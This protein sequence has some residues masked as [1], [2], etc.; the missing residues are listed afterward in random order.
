MTP[1]QVA[2]I[3]GA[4]SDYR[5]GGTAVTSGAQSGFDIG[6][7]NLLAGNKVTVSFPVAPGNAPRTLTIENV[8]DPTALPL[9]SPD[10]NNPVV[11]VD[12][13]GGMASLVNALNALPNSTLAFSNPSGTTLRVLDGGPGTGIAI[14]AILNS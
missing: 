14:N 10:P 5:T 9:P 6:V 1:R 13:S 8:K 3:S 12:F 2:S 7:G 11:G 4:L